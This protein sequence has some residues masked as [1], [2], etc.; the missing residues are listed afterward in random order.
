LRKLL[1][2]KTALWGHSRNFQGQHNNKFI[3][4][5]FEAYRQH[6]NNSPDYWFS[7]TDLTTNDLIERGFNLEKIKT[8]NNSVEI[9]NRWHDYH[10][11]NGK[12]PIS[13][14]FCGALYKAKRIDFIIQLAIVLKKHPVEFIISGDGPEFSSIKRMIKD[15]KLENITLTGRIEGDQKDHLFKQADFTIIPGLVGLGI[16]DSF[17]YGLP[18]LTL[19]SGNHS[20]EISYFEH[21]VN[22][23][24]LKDDVED[25]ACQILDLIS[26]P[27][28]YAEMSQHS[29]SC[30]HKFSHDDFIQNIVAGVSTCLER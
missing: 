6:V 20:P 14:L 7:Y 17:A 23:I 12:E 2:K 26:D 9:T 29:R 18:L 30:Y 4:A 15:E 28:R 10:S 11:I 13:I 16:I 1:G 24:Y 8:I 21:N 5:L 22:G 25:A 3:N 27:V 19:K